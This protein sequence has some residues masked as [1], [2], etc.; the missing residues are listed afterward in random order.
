MR[1]PH[2]KDFAVPPPDGNLMQRA[3]KAGRAVVSI[4]K[5]GDI[6]AHRDTGLERKG[7]SN[8][9]NVDL[10]IEALK[11]HAG[12]RARSS[13]IWS[14]STPNTAIAV[15]FRASPPASRRSTAA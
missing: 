9:G 4:G 15:T 5:I 13:S 7:K 14:T 2:R 1:T 12:R 6:F 11:D 10:L 8:D 3:A